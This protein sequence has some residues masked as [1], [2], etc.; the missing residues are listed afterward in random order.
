MASIDL[1]VRAHNCLLFHFIYFY[2]LPQ[3]SIINSTLRNPCS[4][5]FLKFLSI[6]VVTVVQYSLTDRHTKPMLHM[7][8][9]RPIFYDSPAVRRFKVTCDSNS[10]Y[11]FRLKHAIGVADDRATFFGQPVLLTMLSLF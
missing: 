5:D 2:C 3:P 7:V 4:L 8:N 11:G 10:K 9:V 1:Y 6:P